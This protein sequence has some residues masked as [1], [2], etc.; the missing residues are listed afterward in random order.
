MQLIISSIVHKLKIKCYLYNKFYKREKEWEVRNVIN[1]VMEKDRKRKTGSIEN[2]T[3]EKHTC[4]WGFPWVIPGNAH[5]HTII[6]NRFKF[7][8]VIS[9]I[10]LEKLIVR[11]GNLIVRRHINERLHNLTFPGL[12]PKIRHS[13]GLWWKR[14]KSQIKDPFSLTWKWQQIQ[15]I[16][17]TSHTCMQSRGE[18]RRD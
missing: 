9:I 16:G 4:N 13:Y 3:L 6:L 14:S 11:R 15:K 12:Y 18:Q 8:M 17:M 7:W 10:Y 5:N 2:T 1:D